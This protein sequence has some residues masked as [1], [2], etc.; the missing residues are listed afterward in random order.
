MASMTDALRKAKAA[1]KDARR[2]RDA[3]IASLRMTE[4]TYGWFD[5]WRSD[6]ADI[7]GELFK[8][9][10]QKLDAVTAAAKNLERAETAYA[11]AVRLTERAKEGR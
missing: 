1:E 3:A 5:G 9:A 11:R 6:K 2:V 8:K 10:M 7:S 4:H